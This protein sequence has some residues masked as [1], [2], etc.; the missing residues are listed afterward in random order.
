MDALRSKAR[1]QNP[2][3][4]IVG[5]RPIVFGPGTLWRGAPVLFLWGSAMTQAPKGRL[6]VTQDGILGLLE[7]DS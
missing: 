2:A 5:L 3:N 1:L 4:A 7:H 6:K